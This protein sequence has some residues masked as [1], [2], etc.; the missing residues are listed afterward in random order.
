M[1]PESLTVGCLLAG[2]QSRRMGGGDKCLMEL[3]GRPMLAHVIDRLRPQVSQLVLNANGNPARFAAF[4]LPVTPDPV[5][6][7]VGPLG[8]IL[9]GLVWARAN[10]P[11]AR[12]VATAASDTPFFPPDL[13][14]RLAAAIDYQ[15]GWIALARS[16]D[17]VHPV[18][19]LWPVSL[20]DDLDRAVRVDDLHKVLVWV[21]RHPNVEVAFEL[22]K[23]NGATVDPFFNA[24]TQEDFA[25]ALKVAEEMKS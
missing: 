10:A 14:A 4:D 7:F 17:R 19:G 18:F 15:D 5:E 20:A 23:V 9:A 2:G 3:D 16:G 22:Q 13:V 24:N 11:H 21:D 8:G 12:W 25:R 6:G 1:K